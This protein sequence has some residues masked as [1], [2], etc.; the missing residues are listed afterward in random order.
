MS[1]LV[2]DI[3]LGSSLTEEQAHAIFAL[4]E[5]AV[6][7][8]L[9]TQAKMLAEQR[10]A[11]AATSHQTPST[12]SGMKPVFQKPSVTVH[13]KKKPGQKP[14]HLGSRREVP[15]HI[16]RRMEHR[17]EVCPDCGG[18]LQRCQETRTRYTED[19]PEN[20]QPVITEHTIHRDRCPQ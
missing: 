5:A 13:G 19:I 1:E 18:S 17:A 11:E 14:G 8:A 12:P 9:L 10:V 2:P 15:A 16:D 4:G 6:V 3:Y 7:F 20:I